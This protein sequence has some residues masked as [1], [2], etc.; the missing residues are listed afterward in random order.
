MHWS[1]CTGL[2]PAALSIQFAVE[3]ALCRTI[4]QSVL[5]QLKCSHPALEEAGGEEVE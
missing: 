3:K 2:S 1:H 5:Q 4:G